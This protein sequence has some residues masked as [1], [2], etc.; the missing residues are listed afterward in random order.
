M[1]ATLLPKAIILTVEP[2]QYD[3]KG[4]YC[5]LSSASEVFFFFF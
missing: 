3:R 1:R 5:D 2:S 4:V